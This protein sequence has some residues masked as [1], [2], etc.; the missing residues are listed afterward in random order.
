MSR[1]E[2]ATRVATKSGTS[3]KVRRAL[4]QYQRRMR[5]PAGALRP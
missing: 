4:G 3:A 2:P 1:S 5:R